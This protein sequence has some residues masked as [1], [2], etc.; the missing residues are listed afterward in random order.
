MGTPWGLT[1]SAQPSPGASSKTQLGKVGT[2]YGNVLWEDS[3][4]R[5][6]LTLVGFGGGQH[7]LGGHA[8]TNLSPRSSK[9]NSTWFRAWEKTFLVNK[10]L[11]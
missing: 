2:F 5:F 9:A 7:C 11:P 3:M 6:P 1:L 10:E 4:G 8:A